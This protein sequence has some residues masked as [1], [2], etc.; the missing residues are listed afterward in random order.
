MSVKV[1]QVVMA[2]VKFS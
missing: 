1:D 2:T